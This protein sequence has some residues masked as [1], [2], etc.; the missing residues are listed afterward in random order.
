MAFTRQHYQQIA[1]ILKP[2]ALPYRDSGDR[3]KSDPVF[4]IVVGLADLF[5]EDNSRFDRDRFFAAV[6]PK[7]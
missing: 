1:E 4:P 2:A 3:I 7:S 5:E 6:Y